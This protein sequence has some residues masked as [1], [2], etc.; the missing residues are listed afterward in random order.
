[1]RISLAMGFPA[2]L[3]GG[4]GGKRAKIY[5]VTW[6][7]GSSPVMA[8]TDDAEDMTTVGVGLVGDPKV[9]NDFDDAEIYRDFIIH[10]DERGNE[11]VGIPTCWIRKTKTGTQRTL[12]VSRK[13]F[14]GAYLP[15][16][17]RDFS[18]GKVLPYIYVGRYLG[19]TDGSNRLQSIPGV[20]PRASTNIVN[21]RIYARNNGAGYQLLDIHTID[22][23][24]SLM[25]VEFAT[26]HLQSLMAGYTAGR[27]N[28]TDLA[29][30]SESATNRIVV[31]NAVAANFVVGQ[32]VGVG[33]S[34]GGN[35][36]FYGR[37]I[38]A[39]DTYDDDNKAIVFDGAPVSI[40]TENILYSVG[41]RNGFSDDLSSSS[42]SPVS[43]SS[44][45]YPMSWRKIESVYGN[46]RQCVDGAN[47]LNNRGWVCLDADQ[48]AS[49]LFAAPYQM[50]SYADAS[51]SGWICEMGHDPALAFAEFP[52]VVG[53]P[54]A[55][56]TAFYCDYADLAAA[57][58]YVAFFGGNW[59]YGAAAGLASWNL[60]NGSSAANVNV[61][62]RLLKKALL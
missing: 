26:H 25:R 45:K 36:V 9:A 15:A 14:P 47:F 48:Y 20:H 60:F 61:G 30:I 16:C 8:R 52:V 11:F 46:I 42:G 50:L 17:F 33:T 62:A 51:A 7:G 31:T 56:G 18:T 35:Q 40:T 49:N 10:V 53:L 22:V 37:N 59:N 3:L 21:F 41:W 58:Q 2:D 54:G 27:Y 4:R 23:I 38:V 19:T 43:N 57:S 28:A 29:V 55:G 5:G 6:D 39:I 13:P 32:A 12:Q 44:G 24:Q 34:L 1:M